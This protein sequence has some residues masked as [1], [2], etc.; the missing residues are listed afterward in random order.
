MIV[1]SVDFS[2]GR[3][4]KKPRKTQKFLILSFLTSDVDTGHKSQTQK[5]INK[6]SITQGKTQGFDSMSLNPR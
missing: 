4:E 5:S 1:N 3:F 6:P 2:F